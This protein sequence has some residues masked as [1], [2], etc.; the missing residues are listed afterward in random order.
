MASLPNRSRCPP[1]ATGRPDGATAFGEGIVA[2]A[3]S[4]DWGQ[5]LAIGVAPRALALV[6]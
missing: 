5:T 2:D 4:I 1:R 3:L 6:R